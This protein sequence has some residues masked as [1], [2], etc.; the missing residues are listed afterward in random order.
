MNFPTKKEKAI[1]MDIAWEWLSNSLRWWEIWELHEKSKKNTE[2]KC[3]EFEKK[4]EK[5]GK[6]S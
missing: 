4:Q 5:T 6:S 2:A 3:Q 1:C